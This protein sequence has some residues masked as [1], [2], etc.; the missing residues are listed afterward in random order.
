M[1]TL[2]LFMDLCSRPIQ[3]LDSLPELSAEQL[4]AHPGCHPNSIA[5]LLW[6][7]GRE[8]DIQLAELTGGQQVWFAR[9]FREDVDLGD[10]ADEMG[11]GQSAEVAVRITLEDASAIIAY[12]KA[13]LSAVVDYVRALTEE[14]FSEVVDDSRDP[15]VTR[16][17]RLISI[18]ED[19]IQHL[20]Q[21]SYVLGMRL[22]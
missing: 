6:H 16:G 2:D 13:C 14:D 3:L 17:S 1:D 10:S 21:V 19:A 12:D 15:P 8:L 11:F 9:G 4:N 20:A 5:W 18:V 7:S 22:V